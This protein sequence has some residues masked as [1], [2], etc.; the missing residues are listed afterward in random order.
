MLWMITGI[1]P[2]I[3][4]AHLVQTRI[5]VGKLPKE[6]RKLIAETPD[7]ERQKLIER[8]A[9]NSEFMF[10]FQLKCDDGHL[11]YSGVCGDLDEACGDAAF[12]PL[13]YAEAD[14]GATTMEYRRKGSKDEWKVL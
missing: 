4:D 7:G 11:M 12:A 2:E 1:G 13:G 14:V 6:T 5:G 9:M 10:E 8:I 3:S